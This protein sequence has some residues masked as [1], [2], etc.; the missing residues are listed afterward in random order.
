MKS[1]VAADN[2]W[3][4]G[5]DGGL[6]VHL[7][8]DLKYF[9][10]MTLNKVVVMGRETF[11]SLPGKKPLKDRVNIV[12]S[13]NPDFHPDCIVCRS[14]D[15]VFGVLEDYDTEDVFVIG[16]QEIY[17]QFL[18]Y[19]SGHLVTK[20][21]AVFDADK[22]YENLDMKDDMELIKESEVQIENEIEYR[23][24]EYRRK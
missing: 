11:E 21:N 8:G 24:T 22:Y 5:K 10:E 7:P 16:G 6:L 2:N 20:I 1:I 15:E 13:R 17:R 4:I 3:G 12:L 18:P 23:F 14:I 19:C 9:K